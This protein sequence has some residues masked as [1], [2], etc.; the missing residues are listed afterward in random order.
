MHDE[1][2]FTPSAGQEIEGPG[3]FTRKRRLCPECGEVIEEAYL[4][5]NPF[6]E[7]PCPACRSLVSASS[8][9][10]LRV[11]ASEERTEKRYEAS[12]KV[13]YRTY[14]E[15]I[16][17]YTTNVSSG[18]MFINTRRNHEVHDRVELFL[19]VPGLKEPLR[20]IGEVVRTNIHNVSDEDAGIGVR[21]VELDE[22]SRQ[23]LISF[24]RSH[25]SGMGEMG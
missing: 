13:G 4:H 2:E 21:F 20:I 6:P 23:A 24:I 11:P 3:T 12:L 7:F 18:G 15:F 25:E 5:E 14:Q 19:A 9:G 1:T 16:T 10:E 17:E 8:L 22:G